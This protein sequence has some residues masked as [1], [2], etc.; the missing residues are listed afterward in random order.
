MNK[1]IN[2]IF[3][4]KNKYPFIIAEISANHCGSKEIFLKTIKAAHKS[5]V[6]LIKIQTYEPLD[7]TV[8]KINNRKSKIW[9]LY[10][11]A[12]TPFSWHKDAF[13]LAKQ[14]GAILFSTPF[15]I[16]SV[17]FLKSFNVKLFKLSSFEIT[18][19]SLIN[20]I[21]KTRKPLIISS[22][23]ASLD[24]I[25]N[26]IKIIKKYHN[27]ISILHCVSGYPTSISNANLNKIKTLKKIFKNYNIGLS[28]HTNDIITSSS[29]IA[30]GA[31]IIE[32]HFKLKNISSSLDSK[33]SINPEQMKKLINIRNKIFTSMGNGKFEIQPNEKKSILYRRSLYAKK[34]I[35]K[36]ETL[37][38]NNVVCLRP[39][40]GISANF[41]FKVLGKKNLKELKA[42]EPL[43]TKNVLL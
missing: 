40:L 17:H 14:I 12:Q 9:D 29:A 1:D 33:F 4:I 16:R 42:Y 13:K 2:Q 32:K 43:T 21:A 38:K 34:I 30:M 35:K 5:G 28:D 20:E 27:K 26:C 18:D 11:K 8:P 19:F 22:G 25:K 10:Q 41:F 39:N 7:I 6:D 3:D 24:D 23:M 37:T 36:G 15:S 31:K